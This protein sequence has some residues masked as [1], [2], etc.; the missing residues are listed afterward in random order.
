[1]LPIFVP[2]KGR[3]NSTTLKLLAE[4]EL[5]F[6]AIVEPQD[7]EAYYPLWGRDHVEVLPEND[8]GLPYVRNWIL[9]TA[10][11]EDIG[12]YWMFDDDITAFGMVQS[13]KVQKRKARVVLKDSELSFMAS[14]GYG[15]IGLEYQQFAW[16]ATKPYAYNSYCD[17]AVA[18]HAQRV[19]A[20]GLR[21]RDIDLKLD[22]DFTLQVIT[23]GLGVARLAQRCFAAPKNGSNKG[24]L[25]DKYDEPG[26]EAAMSK[27]MMEMWPGICTVQVKKDG[28]VDAKINWREAVAQAKNHATPGQRG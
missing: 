2:S 25:K 10:A 14:E 28:R 13:G 6:R 20:A 21:F 17:V 16:S 5:P 18:I 1:M 24:G 27:R 19:K 9:N 7:Y 8:Q 12:W 3:P 4:S 26:R 11:E 23:A 15:Q 22:R